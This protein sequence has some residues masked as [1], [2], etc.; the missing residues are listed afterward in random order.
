MVERWSEEGGRARRDGVWVVKARIGKKKMKV[1]GH[2]ERRTKMVVTRGGKRWQN[3]KSKL[4]KTKGLK[5]RRG[6]RNWE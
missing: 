4:A 2:E 5:T 1:R 6:E 3:K